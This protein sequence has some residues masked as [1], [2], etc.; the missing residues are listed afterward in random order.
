[1]ISVTDEGPGVPAEDRTR[2]FDRFFRSERTRRSEGTGLGLA[3]VADVA[4]AHGGEVFAGDGPGGHGT[5]MT[6][7]LPR[8]A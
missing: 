2:I 1:M 5:N 8:G 7:V 6:I 3:I 4:R